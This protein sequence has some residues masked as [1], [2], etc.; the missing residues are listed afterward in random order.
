MPT[1]SPPVTP[2]ATPVPTPSPTA[3]P[4]N[5][6]AIDAGG[7]ASGA[8]LADTDYSGGGRAGVFNGAIDTSNVTNPAPQAVYQT[9][10]VGTAFSY[11]LP[12][13][14][15]GTSHTVRLHFAEIHVHSQGQRVFS[16][17]MTGTS[18]TL[19]DFDIVQQA[20]AAHKAIAVTF[21][22]VVADSYGDIVIAFK[23]S[24]FHASV[25][26]IEVL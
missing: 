20:G 19:Q 12:G 17:N 26:G 10:H 14:G 22:N 15:A 5:G 18:Q 4:G 21:N 13:L 16:V 6:I 11:T 9:A 23:A 24:V 3:T 25:N 1:P 7:Q 8:W 2:S